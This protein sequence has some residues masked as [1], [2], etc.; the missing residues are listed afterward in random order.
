[1]ADALA[2]IRSRTPLTEISWL[3]VT[4]LPPVAVLFTVRL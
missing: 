3:N 4:Q 2:L 1:M